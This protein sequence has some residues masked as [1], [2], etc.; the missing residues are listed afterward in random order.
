MVLAIAAGFIAV[1][2]RDL[3]RRVADPRNVRF[4]P[5]AKCRLQCQLF[6]PV[7][8]R[9]ISGHRG[10]RH[11][12]PQLEQF[13]VNAGCTP[14][15]VGLAHAPNEITNV[16]RHFWPTGKAARFPGPMPGESSAVPTEGRVG[17]NH[18]QT[19]PPTGPE[20]VQ[21]NPQEP[22]AA[23]EAQ[24]TRRVL[25]ENCKLVTKREDLRIQGSTGL[26]TGGYQSE[27]CNEKRAHRGSHTRAVR[28]G[29]F[30]S[31]FQF[32]AK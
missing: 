22:V 1:G 10:L 23:V 24:A 13:S 25:L 17:L 9:Q 3:P 18:L 31:S 30:S 4:S 11:R 19:S 21:H 27:K 2:V 29:G 12:N 28:Q 8:P 20:S 16:R 15:G 7:G 26:K 5:E 32:L 6:R 14:Q